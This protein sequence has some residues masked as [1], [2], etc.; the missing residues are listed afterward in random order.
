MFFHH[1]LAR[2]G[3]GGCQA[4]ALGI[5]S[6]RRVGSPG[7]VRKKENIDL[8]STALLCEGR[9]WALGRALGP[10]WVSLNSQAQRI[11]FYL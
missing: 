10:P 9:G 5:R 11:S 4:W 2:D 6:G 3:G 1:S 7:A 8:T